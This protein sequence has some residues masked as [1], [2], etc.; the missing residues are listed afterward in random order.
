MVVTKTI[1][2]NLF[3][4]KE[5]SKN[6]SSPKLYST[7]APYKVEK[8]FYI[9]P[10]FNEE[11][12]LPNLLNRIS[13]LK[14]SN[15]VEIN[16]IVVNDGS[17]DNTAVVAKN[18]AK[19]LK[20]TLVNH[21]HNMGLG[22]AV[23]TGIKEALSQASHNDILIIMDADDTHDVDLLDNM[24]NKIE[25]GADIVIASRFVDGG[26]D[27][28]APVFRRFLSRGA[29]FIFKTFLP[30]NDINDFTS[31]YRAYRVSI[32]KRASVHWGETL[33]MEQ[34]FACM[35][36]LLLKLRHWSPKIDEIPFYLRYDRKMGAS[37]LKL[38]KTLVQ[39]LKLAIRDR[40]SPAPRRK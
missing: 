7:N 11:E 15:G 14:S 1:N 34:G 26:D 39:Y 30:L 2:K 18:S 23:Q 22:Q 20:L 38:F 8:V 40:V 24:I 6:Y 19:G 16:V 25:D 37:K 4:V 5:V 28:S 29:S 12:S 32:L 9:L 21:E 13:N 35:V 27:S 10:A 31:G 36:E 3:S 33:I 17:S